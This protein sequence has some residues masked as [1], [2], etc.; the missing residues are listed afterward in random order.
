MSKNAAETIIQTAI[1]N[2]SNKSNI[3]S[4]YDGLLEDNAVLSNKKNSKALYIFPVISII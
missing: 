4:K 1:L 2:R 3:Y